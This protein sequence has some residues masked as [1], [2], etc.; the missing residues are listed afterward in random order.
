MSFIMNE[1]MDF[2]AS[3][4]EDQIIKLTRQHAMKVYDTVLELETAIKQ[5]CDEN[6]NEA[7]KTI[8]KINDIENEA[9]RI[10]RELMLKLSKSLLP[11]NIRENLA[12]LVKNLDRLANCAN[13]AARRLSIIEPDIIKPICM[14]LIAFLSDSRECALILKN[15]L[16]NPISVKKEKLIKEIQKINEKEHEVD[17]DHLELRKKLHSIDFSHLNPFI[18]ITVHTLIEFIESIADSAEDTADFLKIVFLRE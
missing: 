2:F 12:H 5:F 15:M 17:M 16:L 8:S 10:R 7:K 1:L 3:R 6:L 4:K 9:D 11:S 13:G 18:A 14:D